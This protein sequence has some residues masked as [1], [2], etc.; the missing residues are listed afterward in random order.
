PE[1][2][3]GNCS[4][5]G[6]GV[7]YFDSGSGR[8]PRCRSRSTSRLLVLAPCPATPEGGSQM[9]CPPQ[10]SFRQ[11]NPVLAVAVVLRLLLGAAPAHAAGLKVSPEAVVLDGP[12]STQQLLVSG[13][14][15]L[16]HQVKYEVADAKVARVS[17]TGLLE[18]RAEGAT[19]ILIRHEGQLAR[20][21]V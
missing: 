20:V 5:R 7:L 11:R 2:E 1:S 19:E 4:R 16:T 13:A 12:E 18:P 10:P 9:R 21:R 15:D 3:T 6:A 14:L 17:G 8:P